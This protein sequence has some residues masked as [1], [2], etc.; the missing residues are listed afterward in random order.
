MD[1]PEDNLPKQNLLVMQIIAGALLAG[2]LVFLAIVFSIV[3]T[4]NGLGVAPAADLPIISIVA[5]IVL[6][7]QIPLAFL[8]PGMLTRSMLQKIA[9]GTWQLPAGANADAFNS[10]ASKLLGLRQSTMIIGLALLEGAAFFG[11]IAYLLE[12]R[13]FVLSVALIALF[14]MAAC[15]PTEPRVRAWLARQTDQLER[16]RQQGDGVIEQ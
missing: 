16:L 15:F 14:L 11:C 13:P 9:S 4:R 1:T 5:I 12:A 6:V 10:D 7:V 3:F 2:V 8:V